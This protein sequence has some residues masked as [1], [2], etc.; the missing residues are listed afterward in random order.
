[1]IQMTDEA[2][3][4]GMFATERDQG[5]TSE[6]ILDVVHGSEGA[7]TL[8]SRSSMTEVARCGNWQ[9][10]AMNCPSTE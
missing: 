6:M 7:S 8:D 10:L 3:E 2:A 4:N 1:M 5:H 9:S